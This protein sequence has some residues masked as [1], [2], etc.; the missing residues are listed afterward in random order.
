MIFLIFLK[1]HDESWLDLDVASVMIVA[2]T[3][4]GEPKWDVCVL[5]EKG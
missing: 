4:V 5:T 2:K 1:I 3:W